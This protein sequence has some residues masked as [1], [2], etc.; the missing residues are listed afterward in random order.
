MRNKYLNTVLGNIGLLTV[1]VLI[2]GCPCPACDQLMCGDGTIE[3]MT[4]EARTCVVAPVGCGDGTMEQT[5]GGQRECVPI[6]PGDILECG[7][8]THQQEQ[9]FGGQRE[10]VPE[11]TTCGPG[12]IE[13][14]DQN[15]DVMCRPVDTVCGDGTFEQTF[16][17]QR[18]CV[19]DDTG[20]SCG[21]GTHEVD[22]QCELM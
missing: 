13:Y 9:T 22:G 5:F 11:E 8:D 4:G 21:D 19:P 2:A 15:S 3:T 17:G 20:L 14:L 1:S 7:A 6:D 12:E 16:G 18:E 10:C